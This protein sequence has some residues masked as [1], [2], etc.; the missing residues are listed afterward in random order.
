[1]HK[2]GPGHESIDATFAA[3]LTAVERTPFAAGTLV[4]LTADHGMA[5][6]DPRRTVYVNR[7]WPEL[8]G[9]LSTGADGKPLA[10]AG[11]CRDLFLHVR[12][13]HVDEVRD[14]LAERLDGIADVVAT[15]TL[16]AEG[17]FAE[18]SPQLRARLADI[19]VLPRYGEAVYWHEP[20]RFEQHL[21]G[22]HGGLSPVEM[23]IPLLAW[24]A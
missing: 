8:A 15:E 20:G 10:P 16:V 21:R 2:I 3:A 6:V 24:V 22:Q 5:P 19:V 14:G 12:T 13:G 9:L 1:M 23:E 4:L 7:V 17:V 11:S 18:P